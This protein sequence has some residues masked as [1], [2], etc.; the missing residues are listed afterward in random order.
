MG[1]YGDG[2]TAKGD[3]LAAALAEFSDRG[4]EKASLRAIASRAGVTT[5]AIYGHFSN[6]DSLFD[7]LVEEPA[8]ELFARYRHAQ[9]KALASS[10]E[11]DTLDAV[12]G[13]E[14]ALVQSWYDY[15]YEHRDSFLLIL[16][17]SAGTRWE[18]YLD[19]FVDS[20]I[21]T[22]RAYAEARSGGSVV[23]DA[24]AP[25]LDRTLSELF[26]RSFFRPLTLGLG[27]EDA[28]RFIVSCNKFFRAGYQALFSDAAR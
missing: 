10:I 28:A 16:T 2:R 19:R 3:I 5:G 27:R 17:R 26:V 1:R 6:K 23:G 13:D 15:I 25:G 14:D 22:T 21:E 24:L 4:F 9:E 8:E 11:H 7:A 18:H 12:A 20:E